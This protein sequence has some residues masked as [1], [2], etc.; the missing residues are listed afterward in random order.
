[1]REAAGVR[2]SIQKHGGE[3][4]GGRLNRGHQRL[5]H[6]VKVMAGDEV[7]RVP[8]LHIIGGFGEGSSV[9]K[10]DCWS[11]VC[12][13]S[14]EAVRDVTLARYCYNVN[15]SAVCSA[16]FATEPCQRAKRGFFFF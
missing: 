3:V 7:Y 11:P 12:V 14:E 4:G 9:H 2:K 16:S 8:Q 15:S 5:V 10:P 1:M 6:T 13:Q